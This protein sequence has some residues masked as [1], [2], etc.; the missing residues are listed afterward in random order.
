MDGLVEA[1]IFDG[2]SD[3]GMSGVWAR[4]AGDDVDVR[5]S[6]DDV[7]WEESGGDSDGEKLAFSGNDGVMGVTRERGGPCAGAVDEADGTEYFG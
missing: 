3:D 7:E 4:G 1:L 6:K 2:G 5:R